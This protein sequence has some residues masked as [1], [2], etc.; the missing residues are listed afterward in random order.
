MLVKREGSE[1]R[2]DGGGRTDAGTDLADARKEDSDAEG[3]D[4]D[5]EEGTQVEAEID[6][7]PGLLPGE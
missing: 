2:K 4:R 6:V 5:R 1:D 7:V 3:E